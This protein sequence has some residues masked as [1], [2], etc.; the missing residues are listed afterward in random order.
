MCPGKEYARFKILVFM[1]NLV[2]RFK[3]EMVFPDE[4]MIMDPVLVP[5]K[6][7]AIRLFPR[8]SHTK[9]LSTY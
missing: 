6:G 9:G 5:T 2:T 1:H 4:K 3:W 7:L 8:S